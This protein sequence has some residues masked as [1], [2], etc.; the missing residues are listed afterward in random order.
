MDAAI[1]VQHLLE[2]AMAKQEKR[3]KDLERKTRRKQRSLAAGMNFGEFQT[4]ML[5]AKVN[6]LTLEQQKAL[7]KTIDAD[8]SGTITKEELMKL[9]ELRASL[10]IQSEEALAAELEQQRQVRALE[11]QLERERLEEEARI[12]EEQRMEREMKEKE[13]A[14]KYLSSQQ[15]PARRTS[16]HTLG[17]P[18]NSSTNLRSFG[19]Q[20][21]EEDKQPTQDANDAA[22]AA[23]P[24]N[25]AVPAA[26]PEA[27]PAADPAN[28]DAPAAAPDA[29]PAPDPATSAAPEAAPAADPANDAAPAAAPD[30]APAAAPAAD[31]IEAGNETPATT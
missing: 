3:Q 8:N 17:S 30:A 12:E 7:F 29:A 10:Q 16:S 27:A 18:L 25:D 19:L 6:W 15:G 5:D 1:E 28:D 13:A 22:P 2:A 11:E 4:L 20:D 31:P 26:A 14:E 23:D 21:Q 24:A 9:G